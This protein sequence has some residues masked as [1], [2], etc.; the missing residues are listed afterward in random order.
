MSNHGLSTLHAFFLAAKAEG[1][2][3]FRLQFVTSQRGRLAFRI[4][5]RGNPETATFEVRGNTVRVAAEDANFVPTT[6]DTRTIDYG[7]TRSGEQPIV[8]CSLRPSG[9]TLD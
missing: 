2:T 3:D 1:H 7:G 5:P 4:C 8:S 9:E 6:E